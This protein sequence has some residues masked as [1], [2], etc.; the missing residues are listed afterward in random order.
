M[1]TSGKTPDL[2]AGPDS[3]V[4]HF[5]DMPVRTMANGSESRNVLQGKTATGDAVGIHITTQPKGAQPNPA[6]ARI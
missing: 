4:I 5:S 1:Q 2:A 3:R 6:S